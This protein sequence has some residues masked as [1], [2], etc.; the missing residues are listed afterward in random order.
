MFRI[1]FALLLLAPPAISAQ[2]L[3]ARGVVKAIAQAELSVE[4]GARVQKIPFRKGD[5]FNEGDLLLELDCRL[6]KAQRDKVKADLE[7]SQIQLDNNLQLQKVRSIGKAKVILSRLARDKNWAEHEM[8]ELNVSRC[9]LKA[10]WSGRVA[11]VHVNKHETVE[12]NEKVMNIV[13]AS[14]LEIEFVIP[15]T[16]LQWLKAGQRYTMKIDETGE[17]IEGKV[18]V[19]GAVV[20]PMSQTIGLRSMVEKVGPVLP[21]MSGTALFIR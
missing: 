19:V 14:P 17:V 13:A 11:A 1:L 7:A 20:D 18:D 4:I 8:V 3:Q 15:A 2:N 5:S 16:W 6:Y 9:Y 12:A 21:G 10:P